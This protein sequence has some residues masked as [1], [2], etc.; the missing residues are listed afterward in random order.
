MNLEVHPAAS[1]DVTESTRFFDERDE[2]LGDD[3]FA[4]WR[5]AKAAILAKPERYPLA[6]DSPTGYRVRYYWIRRFKYRVLYWLHDQTIYIL[7]VSRSRR[8]PGY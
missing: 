5:D 1:D 2:T 6:E 4:S 7:A 8:R 3:F